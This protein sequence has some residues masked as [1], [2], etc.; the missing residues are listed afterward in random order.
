MT[1]LTLPDKEIQLMTDIT[2]PKISVIIPV[3]NA[4][5]YLKLAI[6]SILNQ[7][8]QNIEIIAIND[9]ST[10]NSMAILNGYSDHRLKFFEN[11]VNLGM[12]ATRN[13]AISLAKGEYI[14]FFDNDDISHPTRLSQELHFLESHPD[15]AVVGSWARFID[16]NGKPF[17]QWATPT[18]P[19]SVFKAIV[20]YNPI[21]NTS[22]L[23]RKSVVDEIGELRGSSGVDDYEYWLRVAEKHKI[24][25][26]PETLV[27]Y[28]IHSNQLSL[29]KLSKQVNDANQLKIAFTIRWKSLGILSKNFEPL[30][31]TFWGKITGKENSVAKAYLYWARL[32]K[33]MGNE[34]LSNQL[35]LR[36]ILYAPLSLEAITL[37]SNML[38]TRI[39][40]KKTR[41]TLS[42][43]FYRISSLLK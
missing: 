7:T 11:T 42:W 20:Q 13:N 33:E 38:C 8:L 17:G 5:R 24:S 14:A 35:A 9:G 26:I 19:D 18:E 10:D 39:L 16:E 6:D 3:F 28:R 21:I 32:Y 15:I 37:L 27:D 22:V 4:E 41:K 1:E 43:Y 36:T 30:I 34:K 29:T 23:M 31:P 2:H 25:N 40:S 12:V